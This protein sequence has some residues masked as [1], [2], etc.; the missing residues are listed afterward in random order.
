[1]IE[2]RI[3]EAVW[4]KR[5]EGVA[6]LEIEL[7]RM[8]RSVSAHAREQGVPEAR[9]SVLN[10]VVFATRDVHARR[11][12]A[13]I[14]DLAMRH[15]SRAIVVLADRRREGVAPGLQMHC[16]LSGPGGREQVSCEHIL[17]RA[18][19]DVDDRIA[20]AVIPLLLPDLPVFLWWTG[21]PPLDAPHFEELVGLADRLIV[22]SGDFARP[23]G[24]LPRLH[25]VARA[26]HG[27][28]GLTDF[29]WTRITAWR[30][31]VSQFF[32]VPAWRPFLDGV[33]GLRIGFAVDADGREIHPSQALLLIFLAYTWLHSQLPPGLVPQGG[34][35]G[36]PRASSVPLSGEPRRSHPHCADA[37][38]NARYLHRVL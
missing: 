2:E 4:G 11:A 6:A 37:G 19:G 5:A 9:A 17:I 35:T 15:P 18:R 30:E 26:G 10:L 1:M 21:T 31:L 23:A 20:S 12:A 34:Q 24:T 22:D 14:D 27:R 32:D 25:A 38:D 29:N 16:R 7:A 28:H 8:R 13:T 3:D 33:T 36:E